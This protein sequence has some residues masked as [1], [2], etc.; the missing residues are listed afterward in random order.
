LLR[1]IDQIC[2]GI[3]A[4][5]GQDVVQRLHILDTEYK[6][7]CRDYDNERTF[8][9]HWQDKAEMVDRELAVLQ[10][11]VESSS[12]IQV[13]IDGDAAYFHDVFIQAGATG[14]SEAAHKLLTEI[15]IHVQKLNIDSELPI[16]VQ[17]YANIGGLGG[18]LAQMGLINNP[19]DLHVSVPENYLGVS[20]SA[21]S[22]CSSAS[23]AELGKSRSS[24]SR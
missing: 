22:Y 20:L 9:H 5:S 14:A 4:D 24:C 17:I 8:R 16:F 1:Y 23:A 2:D 13:L 3:D 11:N 10:A 19:S 15:K 18:K 21:I 6:A 7:K 12:F